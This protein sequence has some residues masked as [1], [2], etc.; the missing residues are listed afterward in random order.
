MADMG[1]MLIVVGAVLLVVG[2]VLTFSGRVGRLPGD[3]LIKRDS[4]V[5]YI[6]IMTSILLSLILTLVLSVFLRR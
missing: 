5:V 2:V 1:R 3:I 6:P 4:F